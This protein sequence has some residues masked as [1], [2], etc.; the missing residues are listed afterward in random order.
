V[1][2]HEHTKLL[3]NTLQYAQSVVLSECVEE[4][5]DDAVLVGAANVLLE[6]LDNLL[7]VRDGERGSVEDLVKLGVLLEDSLKSLERLCGGVEGVGL[8]GR[9][10]LPQLLAKLLF[11]SHWPAF[12]PRI[13][14]NGPIQVVESVPE[15]SRRF[16]R[17]QRGQPG[18]CWQSQSGRRRQRS[19]GSQR[20]GRPLGRGA[21]QPGKR[22]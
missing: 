5:L 19:F 3:Y 16:R 12:H 11:R 7:L 8:G 13:I 9:G 21:H 18:A 14:A 1:R 17:R 4:V 6:L 10:V 22:C 15:H 20:S 2:T